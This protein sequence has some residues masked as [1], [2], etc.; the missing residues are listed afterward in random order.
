LDIGGAGSKLKTISVGASRGLS[1]RESLPPPPPG[2]SDIRADTDI[3]RLSGVVLFRSRK[4]CRASTDAMDIRGDLRSRRD[5]SQLF[6]TPSLGREKSGRSLEMRSSWR[7]LIDW[8]VVPTS[9]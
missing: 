5:T 2:N 9:Q 7:I 4:E 1:A 6:M 8:S 3:R